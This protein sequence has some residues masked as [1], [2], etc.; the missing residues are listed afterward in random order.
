MRLARF[1][2][3][4]AEDDG[5]RHAALDRGGAAVGGDEAP[6]VADGLDG[7]GVERGEAGGAADAYVGGVA[8]GGDEHVEL[9][10]AL[11]AEAARRQ[12]IRRQRVGAVGDARCASAVTVAV[13]AS[14]TVPGAG[15]TTLLSRRRGARVGSA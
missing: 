13:T 12:R 4:E 8:V 14:S 1:D 10:Q 9:D 5:D 15:R 3:V 7:G 6:A 11:H 2:A